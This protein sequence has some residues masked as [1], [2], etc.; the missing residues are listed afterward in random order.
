MKIL[1]S[2][3]FDCNGKVHHEFLLQGRKQAQLWF[4]LF[5]KDINDDAGPGRLITSTTDETIEAV[6]K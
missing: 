4:N 6:K 5:R 1:L 2:L 3:F